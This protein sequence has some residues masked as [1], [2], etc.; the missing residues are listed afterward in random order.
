MHYG[1]IYFSSSTLLNREKNI[2]HGESYYNYDLTAIIDIDGDGINELIIS[3]Y[4]YESS[5]FTI[6]KNIE[7]TWE[8]IH[9][10]GGGGC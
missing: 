6:Y 8:K 4:G 3:E 2:N 7:N 9:F 1:Y 5:F 10:G